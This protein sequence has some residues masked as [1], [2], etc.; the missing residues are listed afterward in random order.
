MYIQPCFYVLQN[1]INRVF[2]SQEKRRNKSDLFFFAV[3]EEGT[4]SEETNLFSC[5][6]HKNGLYSIPS[7]QSHEILNSSLCN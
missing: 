6:D 1:K 3:L 7:N 2:K 4:G 5:V